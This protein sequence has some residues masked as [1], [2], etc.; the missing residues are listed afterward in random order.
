MNPTAHETSVAHSVLAILTANQQHA[1]KLVRIW[2]VLYSPKKSRMDLRCAPA[3]LR[4]GLIELLPSS[5]GRSYHVTS[6]GWAVDR[7]RASLIE[8]AE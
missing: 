6:A 3:L 2:P 1:L 8:P 7:A 5:G 4:L